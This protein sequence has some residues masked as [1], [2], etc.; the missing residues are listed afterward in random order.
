MLLL[1]N[2][3]GWYTLSIFGV[4][5]LALG[6]AAILGFTHA[7]LHRAVQGDAVPARR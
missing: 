6:R 1:P 2:I 5:A 7:D 4:Q 3:L